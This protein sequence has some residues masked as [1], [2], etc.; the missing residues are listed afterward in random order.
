MPVQRGENGM[1][2][3]ITLEDYLYEL[4]E[5]NKEFDCDWED[6]KPLLLALL[7]KYKKILEADSEYID[8]RI[9]WLKTQIKK[10]E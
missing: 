3:T 8:F 9:D 2:K 4:D 7:R 10:A 5:L 6:K 1:K